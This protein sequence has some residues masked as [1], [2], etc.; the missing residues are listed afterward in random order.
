MEMNSTG[1]GA[2][3]VPI[4]RRR[5]LSHR[6]FVREYLRPQQPVILT[7]AIDHWPALG[8]WTPEFFRSAFG[9]RSVTVDGQ[10]YAL[11]DLLTFIEHSSKARPA[12]YLRNLLIGDWAPELLEDI[13]PM[14]DCTRPN[15]L[16]SPLF[17][18]REATTA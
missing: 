1:D 14:P 8:R 11:R 7:D 10:Q 9:L 2:A 3:G 12:P 16:G 18:D 6:D 17:H 4:D 15:W 5:G 13:L